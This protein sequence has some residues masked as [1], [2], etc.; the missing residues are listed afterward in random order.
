[1]ADEKPLLAIDVDGVICPYGWDDETGPPDGGEWRLMNGLPYFVL[2][3]AGERLR[4]LEE[5]Y[6]LVW[7]TGWEDRANDFLPNL[8]G[9]SELPIVWFEGTKT[10]GE[11]HWKL[12]GLTGYAGARPLAWIDD[13]FD[14]SCHAWAA[15]RRAPTLLV[16]AEA[17]IGIEDA[18]VE[19]M[20]RWAEDGFEPR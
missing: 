20:L 6:E 13:S 10:F 9:I 11:A 4:R 3:V 5:H 8:L 2:T 18:H 15:A 16:E 17:S 7:A 14:E 12:D 1:M 19:T